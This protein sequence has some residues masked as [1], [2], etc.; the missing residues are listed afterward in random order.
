MYYQ[1]VMNVLDDSPNQPSKFRTENWVKI[2]EESRGTNK[3]NNNINLET[4]MIR[5]RLCYYGD[6]C[7]HDKGT[8]TIPNIAAAGV[9]AKNANKKVIIKN[10]SLFTD[11]VSKI[12][13]TNID[14]VIYID[15]VIPMYNLIEHDIYSKIWGSLEVK[16]IL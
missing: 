16:A 8:I 4:L 15:L 11:C 1:K 3:T 14:G 2:N 10:C 7:I 6:A 13:Y 9:A 12:S 5:S